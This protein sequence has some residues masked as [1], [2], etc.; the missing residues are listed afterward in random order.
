VRWG[1]VLVRVRSSWLRVS[2]RRLSGEILQ[3]HGFL[4][5]ALDDFPLAGNDLLRVVGS[6]LLG[7]PAP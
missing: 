1:T 3:W 4:G 7:G 2:A 5:R 6:K